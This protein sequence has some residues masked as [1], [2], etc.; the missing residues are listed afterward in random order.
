[1]TRPMDVLAQSE[2]AAVI[3]ALVEGNS[4]RSIERMTGIHLDTVMRLS[5]RVGEG[6][7]RLLDARVRNVHAKRVQVD[8]I[9]TFVVVKQARLNGHH[10]HAEMG[11]QYVSVGMDSDSKPVISHLVGKR[12]ATTANYF[13]QD[14]K[15]RLANR[16]QLTTDGF[17][18]YIA[19]VEDAFGLDVDYAHL[20]KLYWSA[21]GKRG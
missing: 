16:V 11:E 17:K 19:A 14:L 9:W 13:M 12:D 4:V 20:V 8:E 7:A 3:G 2:Q 1:M 18:P 15:E 21:K 10:N 6:C 5:A